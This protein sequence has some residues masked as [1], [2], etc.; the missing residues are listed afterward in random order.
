MLEKMGKALSDLDG[1]Y[2]QEIEALKET[3]KLLKERIKAG[4]DFVLL[5]EVAT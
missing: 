3:V 4:T 1:G 5:P 2:S